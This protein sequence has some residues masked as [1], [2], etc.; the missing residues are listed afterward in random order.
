M[1]DVAVTGPIHERF[2]EVLTDDALQFL[3]ALH[4]SLIHI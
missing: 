2:D 4:L 1:V 3:A